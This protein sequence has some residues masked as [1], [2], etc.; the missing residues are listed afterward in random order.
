MNQLKSRRDTLL[1]DRRRFLA[2]TAAFAALGLTPQRALALA[3]PASFKQGVFEVTV[4]SDG[5]LAFPVSMLAP[6]APPDA[7]KALLAAAG[8]AGDEF[9]AP[10]NATVIKAGSDLILFDTGS[11]TEFQPTAGKLLEN[12]K[13]GGIDP[14]AITKVVFTHAHPDHIWG[15]V[16]GSNGLNYPNAAYYCGAVEWDFW[17]GK[18]IL[19]QMPKEMHPFVIGA[20]KH[21]TRA[22]DRMTLLKGGDEVVSGI[23]MLETF[24]HTPGHA[25]FEIDG[26]GGLIVVADS[27]PPPAVWFPHPEW[28]MGFDAIP[29]MAVASRKKLLGRAADEKIKMIGFHWPYPGVGYAERKDDA[30]AY[31]AA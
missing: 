1:L 31:A 3:A 15:T 17:M 16:N 19:N 8:V 9:Q 18:D 2:A 12:L 30:F 5:H 6:D 10:V 4:V 26:D 25:S 27:V 23:R 11:G 14:A 28:R 22:K 7:V 20:Q 21:L 13:L 24:G 29:E